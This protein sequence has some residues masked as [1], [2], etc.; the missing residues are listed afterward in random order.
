MGGPD[1]HNQVVHYAELAGILAGEAGADVRITTDL[2]TLNPETLGA[3]QAIVNWSTFVQPTPEQVSALID[4][5]QGG[6]GLFAIHGGAATFWNSAPYLTL[7]GSRFLRHDPYKEFLVEIED[8]QHPITQGVGNFLIEDEL[9][10][11]GGKVEDFEVFAAAVTAGSPYG[12]EV[13]SLGEGP[14]GPD[15]Q[16]LA[17]AEGHPLLYAKT[18]GRG[19]IHYNALGHDEKALSNPNFRRLVSQGLR[20]V[21]AEN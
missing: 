15:I 5:V 21:I 6:L 19:R 4:A 18:H 13:A 16:L 11:Q 9:Y 10:E 2:R 1:Y 8:T 20:W 12:G 7:L 17:S 14:L 3:Y